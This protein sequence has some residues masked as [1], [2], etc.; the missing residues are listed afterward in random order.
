MV[1]ANN[2]DVLTFNGEI[3][4][5]RELRHELEAKGYRFRSQ[6]DTEFY[7]MHSQPKC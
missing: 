6:S 4:N 2:G 1:N 7:F 5:F 3:Y